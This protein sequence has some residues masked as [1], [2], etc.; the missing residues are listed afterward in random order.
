[1]PTIEEIRTE[2]KAIRSALSNL[3][4]YIDG[5]TKQLGGIEQSWQKGYDCGHRDGHK[6]GLLD[7]NEDYGKGYAEGLEDAWEVA[8][9]IV[10]MDVHKRAEVFFSDAIAVTHDEPFKSYS[11]EE[12]MQKLKEYDAIIRQ[13]THSNAQKFVEVFGFAPGYEILDDGREVYP[14]LNDEFWNAEYKEPEAEE[15]EE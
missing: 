3:I 5:K 6:Q 9:R 11:V 10:Q 2:W 12:A 13:V 4:C 14:S 15:G 1:M 8:C 7:A